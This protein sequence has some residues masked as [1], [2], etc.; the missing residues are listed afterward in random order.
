MNLG[1]WALGLA[2]VGAGVVVLSGGA[3]MVLNENPLVPPFPGV[4][5]YTREQNAA[6]IR[7]V[8]SAFGI[9][10]VGQDAA[11]ANAIAESNLNNMVAGD[12]GSSVGLFQINALGRKFA[13]DRRDPVYNALWMVTNEVI[14]PAGAKYLAAVAAGDVRLAAQRFAVD[15]ERPAD[16]IEGGA[17]WHRRG[18]LGEQVAA[19]ALPDNGLAYRWLDG[20]VKAGRIRLATS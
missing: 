17:T 11:I 18:W 13:A 6:Y 8:F 20:E 5:G 2:A 1:W 15:I 7:S 3:P 9:P 12:S 16:R 19:G 4:R 10:K 14:K